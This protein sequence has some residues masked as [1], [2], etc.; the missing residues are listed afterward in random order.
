MGDQ[1]AGELL[2]PDAVPARAERHD[3]RLQSL[4]EKLP[5]WIAAFPFAAFQSDSGVAAEGDHPGIFLYGH[6]DH[7]AQPEDR[8]RQAEDPRDG[9]PVSLHRP[10][11][12][13][14]EVLQSWGL[15][16]K[17]ERIVKSPPQLF[18]LAGFAGLFLTLILPVSIYFR[19]GE[20]NFDEA[21]CYFPA[22]QQLRDKFPLVD[23]VK[24]SL[25]ANPPGYTQLLAGLSLLSGESVPWLRF[26][27]NL[28]SLVGAC[29]LLL[30]VGY[31]C[32][33]NALLFMLPVVL[34]PYYLKQACVISTDN[35]ALALSGIALAL[36]L[37]GNRNPWACV[38]VGLLAAGAIYVRQISAWLLAPILMTLLLTGKDAKGRR[39]QG[40]LGLVLVF[41]LVFVANLAVFWQ[42]LVSPRFQSAHAGLNLSGVVY[43]VSL[44]GLFAPFFFFKETLFPNKNCQRPMIW[45]GSLGVLL[46]ILAPTAPS[47]QDGR[48]G[49]VLWSLASRGPLIADRSLLFFP[50]L[51]FGCFSL[52]QIIH[53]LYQ[54]DKKRALI[55]CAG[56]F[57]WLAT[58]IPNHQVFH[59]YF[60]GPVLLFLGVSACLLSETQ[61][62]KILILSATLLIISAYVLFFTDNG[63]SSGPLF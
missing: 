46:F 42:G 4:P 10:V 20:I 28:V 22:I 48:W 33:P 63:F 14:G 18:W 17:G 34:S 5:G 9:Q 19:A 57:A 21:R 36:L 56:F 7:L 40:I 58:S 37:F 8:D 35:I 27:H 26:W 30:L 51:V 29:A 50:L 60:E 47:Y 62:I 59:R 52:V 25:S 1:P 12:M 24:D 43:G 53:A 38:T 13:A 44:L 15:C 23:L 6:P 45:A 55:W 32:R 3:E 16:A 49:G 41:C 2:H 11:P 39:I 31:L 61:K 54:E